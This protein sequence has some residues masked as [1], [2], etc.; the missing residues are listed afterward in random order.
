MSILDSSIA[1]YLT[2][3]S[4]AAVLA[5]FFRKTLIRVVVVLLVELLLL[6]LFPILLLRFIDL[7]ST[8]HNAVVR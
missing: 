8:V 1:P 3:I 5:G 4:I 6:A 2:L 7:I